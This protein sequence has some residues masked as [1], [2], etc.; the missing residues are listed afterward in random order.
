MRSPQF[1][2]SKVHRHHLLRGQVGASRWGLTRE[3]KPSQTEGAVP[4]SKGRPLRHWGKIKSRQ[5]LGAG[6]G[7]L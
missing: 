7:G 4:K 6:A 5:G 2:G 3:I 1:K